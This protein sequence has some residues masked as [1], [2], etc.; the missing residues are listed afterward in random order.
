MQSPNQQKPTS[1]KPSQSAFGLIDLSTA[2]MAAS[3][4]DQ[5]L[6]ALNQ[7]DNVCF[8]VYTLFKH[9]SLI[10]HYCLKGSF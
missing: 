1:P 7:I 6:D 2:P 10:P 8:D 9:R 3:E 4:V 5:R